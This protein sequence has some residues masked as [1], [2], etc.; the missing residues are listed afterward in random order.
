MYIIDLTLTLPLLA[1]LC[2]ILY[3]GALSRT[4][5]APEATRLHLA[6]AGLAWAVAYPLL[7]L[8]LNFGLASSLEKQYA[9]DG[10]ERGITSV[11]LS[12]EPFAPLNWKV[13]GIA[14]DKY[15]MGRFFLP[16]PSAQIAFSPYDRP[17]PDFWKALRRDI[18][19]FDIYGDFVTYPFQTVSVGPDGETY[20]FADIRYEATLPEL[21]EKVG[22]GDGIF[23]MQAKR[24][25]GKVA[26]YR[27]LYRGR[28][29]ADTPWQS[30]PEDRSHAG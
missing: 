5:P 13:V 4:R 21:M 12:P 23:L 11:E 26:A 30:A 9:F 1:I 19:L 17:D 14:P 3:R 20:T 10:N 24:E 25:H 7:A 27:F 29:A 6:R 15:Y 22:R 8:C 16:D 18:P 2:V 28:E